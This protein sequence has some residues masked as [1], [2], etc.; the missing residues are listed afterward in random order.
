MKLFR[1]SS[2][3]NEKRKEKSRDAARCR[4]SRETEIFTE[5]ASALPMKAEDVDALDKASVMRLSISYLKVRKMVDLCEFSLVVCEDIYL[6]ICY[7][8]LVPNIKNLDLPVDAKP[9]A[10]DDEDE[11]DEDS[12]EES[13][14]VLSKFVE[15]EQFALTALDGFLLVLSDD[16]DITFVSENIS[17]ILGL[18]KVRHFNHYRARVSNQFSSHRLIWW[19]NPSGITHTLAIMM[20]F[21]RR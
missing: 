2:R 21:A 7:F 20:S 3:N 18:S 12:K 17:D 11:G 9:T 8:V 4:R 6:I 19:A 13:M 10:D 1:S 14:K 15:E 16:G 5:L